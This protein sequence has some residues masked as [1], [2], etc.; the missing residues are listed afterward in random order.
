ME[1]RE[2]KTVSMVELRLICKEITQLP[3]SQYF[4]TKKFRNK[5]E[6]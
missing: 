1:E 4:R 6:T 3:L 5:K 2:E